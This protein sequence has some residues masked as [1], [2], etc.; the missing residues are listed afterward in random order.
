MEDNISAKEEAKQ[1]DFILGLVV[2]SGCRNADILLLANWI[3]KYIYEA[4]KRHR[5]LRLNAV[6]YGLKLGGK[7]CSMADT[8]LTIQYISEYTIDG[9][10]VDFDEVFNKTVEPIAIEEKPEAEVKPETK[11]KGIDKNDKNAKG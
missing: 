11:A 6:K 2:E 3:Y 9:K 8:I 7:A 10:I 4:E 1:R 5:N